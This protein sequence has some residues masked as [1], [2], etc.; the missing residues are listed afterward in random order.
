MRSRVNYN[1]R[2]SK[3]FL[4]LVCLLPLLMGGACEKKPKNNGDT[5][6]INALDRAGPGAAQ[7]GPVDESPL[8][9]IDVA[10]LSG[11]KQKLFYKLVGSLSSPCGKAHSLR[12]S[13]T[14]DTACKRAPF[15]VRYVVALL[16]DEGS[17][18]QVREEY[19]KKYKG[20]EKT[21]KLDVSKAPRVGS[22]DAPIR[23]V[24]FFDYQCPHCQQFAPLLEQVAHANEGKVVEYFLMFPLE[25]H[26]DSKSA[27]MAAIAAHQLGK[28]P[29]MHRMLFQRSPRHNKEAVVGYAKELGLDAAKFEAAY[30]AAA[31]QVAGDLGQGEAAGVEATPT[32]FFNDRKYEGPLHP[33]YL[34]MWIEEELAVN[35]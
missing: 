32:L 24:E 20:G 17:E 6:A 19:E 8:Q 7:T 11:D 15:A 10:K 35:R 2:V 26:Q 28:F 25:K 3:P 9:G 16:E 14:Q 18:A 12:T 21:V 4:A 30:N 31:S 29:E 13:F 5:G 1:L 22:D 34:T 33:R 27:A 23:L